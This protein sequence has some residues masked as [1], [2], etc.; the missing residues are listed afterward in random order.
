MWLVSLGLLVIGGYGVGRSVRQC[1][2]VVGCG[3]C[4]C[5]GVNVGREGLPHLEVLESQCLLGGKGCVDV[6]GSNIQ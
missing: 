1:G 2:G 6:H 5:G 3:L 4:C